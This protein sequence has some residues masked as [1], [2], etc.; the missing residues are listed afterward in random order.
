MP[1][2]SPKAIM[3]NWVP[4]YHFVGLNMLLPST[5]GP[6]P[7]SRSVAKSGEPPDASEG[8]HVEKL[9]EILPYAKLDP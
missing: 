3:R 6:P 4:E 7:A 9:A 2:S 8:F 1:I 5:N